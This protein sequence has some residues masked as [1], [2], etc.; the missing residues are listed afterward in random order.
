MGIENA[1][2]LHLHP[3][4]GAI[5]ETAIVLEL[6]KRSLNNGRLPRLYFW[7]DNGKLEI[8]LIDEMVDGPHPIEIKSGRTYRG[9]WTRPMRRWLNTAACSADKARIIYGGNLRQRD[10]EI[11]IVPWFSA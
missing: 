9:E 6:R 7:R 1:S 11:E 5:F 10:Q 4:H 2:Q 8:D 3:Q